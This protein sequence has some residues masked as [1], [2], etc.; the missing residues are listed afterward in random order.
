VVSAGKKLAVI[1]RRHCAHHADVALLRAHVLQHVA[2]GLCD[3]RSR[4]QQLNA[5]TAVVGYTDFPPGK[6]SLN[7][8][9]RA[10]EASGGRW[11]TRSRWAAPAR[12]R[13]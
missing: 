8:F 9:K 5:K 12:C 6:D 2:L 1:E 7:A 3:R 10:F 13:T 4:G 11:L